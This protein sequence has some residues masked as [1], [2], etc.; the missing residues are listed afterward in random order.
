MTRLNTISIFSFFLLAGVFFLDA[1]KKKSSDELVYNPKPLTLT[2]PTGWPQPNAALFANNPPTEA[3]FQLGRKLFYDGKLSKDGNFPCA[4]CH[5]QFAGFATF[6]HDFSHGFNN[7]FTTRNAQPTFNLAWKSMFHWDG[8][9]NHLDQQPLAPLTAQNEMAET[10][11]NVLDK[12]K[13][14]PQ[15]PNLFFKAFGSAEINSQKMLQALSQFVGFMVSANSKYDSVKNGTATFTVGEN[16]G[17]N[18]FKAN[19]AS[20]HKE[21]LFTDH[22]FR[23]NGL[24]VNS[25]LNDRGRKGITQNPTDDLKFAVPSLRNVFLTFPY[26]HDG[27]YQSLE[28]CLDHYTDQVQT[29]QATIDP[30]L[31]NRLILTPAEK[32]YI[33]IF[34]KTL[35]DYTFTKDSRFSAP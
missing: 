1:C 30:L 20:C 19:C 28:Q 18:L 25:F 13:A 15:Y 33:I 23:N 21:P 32:A 27:R 3:G 16:F 26:M 7:A 24:V 22:S 17:Y 34:L 8:G 10:L 31:R 35:T 4:S 5:Q 14:D 2:I 29:Q 9:I 11:V 12:L 6:D